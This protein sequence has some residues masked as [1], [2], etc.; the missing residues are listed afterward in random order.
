MQLLNIQAVAVTAVQQ[1]HPD[2][3]LSVVAI[4][5]ALNGGNIDVFLAAVRGGAQFIGKALFGQHLLQQLLDSGVLGHGIGTGRDPLL[6]ILG[7]PVVDAALLAMLA[8][9]I[10]CK[11]NGDLIQLGD[12][13]R[14]EG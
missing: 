13:H 11:G 5:K 7:R 3:I 14:L 4:G 1:V 2:G 12:R 10:Q 6:E 8:V 9:A